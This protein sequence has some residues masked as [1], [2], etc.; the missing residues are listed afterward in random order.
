M[1]K[2]ITTTLQKLKDAKACVER[3]THLRDALIAYLNDEITEE[4]S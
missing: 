1:K 3:Y 2:P 4:G